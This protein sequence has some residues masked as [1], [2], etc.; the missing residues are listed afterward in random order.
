M[1]NYRKKEEETTIAVWQPGMPS[2][3]KYFHSS[4]VNTH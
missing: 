1:K 2:F 3:T 4:Y